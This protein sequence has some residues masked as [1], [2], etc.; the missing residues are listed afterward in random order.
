MKNIL[1]ITI[2]LALL[3]PFCANAQGDKAVIDKIVASVGGEIIFLSEMQEQMSYARE[4]QT[5]LPPNFECE[6]LQNL[7]MQK[8]LVNQAKLDSLVIGDEEV[9]TQLDARID[10]LLSYFNQDPKGIEDYYGQTI[11][12]IKEQMRGDMRNQ[13][14]AE[15]MQ[16][17]ITSKATITPS[18]VKDFFSK[19][20]K[21]SLP[22]FNAE[23]EIREIVHKPKVNPTQKGIAREKI[24]DI[25]KRIVEGK[26]DFGTL[27]K[28]YS[29]DL[30]SGAQN[31]DLGWQKRGTFVA[32][33]EAMAYKLDKEQISPVVETEFGFH[34]IQLI[35]RRGNLIHARHVLIKPTIT[36]EDFEL[37]KSKLDS[38]R[39]KIVKDSLPFSAAVKLYSDKNVQ[40]YNNDGRVAN[41]RS[42]NTF[43]EMADLPTNIFFAIDGI[44]VGDVSK[45]IESSPDE[46]EKFFRIVM[47][48]GRTKPHKA[49]LKQDYNKIQSAALE[50]KKA[51]FTEKW[52]IERLRNTYLQFD[53]LYGSCP[54]LIEMKSQAKL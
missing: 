42:G 17:E 47:V 48:Q 38:V 8:L 25:R 10:R 39:T 18:E 31:G 1:R 9:E 30:G 14:L 6:A 27:A 29:D 12:V 28:K 44:K 46:G 49:D 26:E 37:A 32:E 45:P 52:V 15:R 24:D 2:F 34:V 13:I 41:P 51:S 53:S 19:I 3:M 4:K 50:Q 5:A 11:D 16:G 54:N 7:V 22:Y 20:P 36:E 35:E 21:D 40:S 33:F 43:Y 23:V